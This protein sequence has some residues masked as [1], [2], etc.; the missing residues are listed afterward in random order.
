M[1]CHKVT[2]AFLELPVLLLSLI[3]RLE[4][5]FQSFDV[6]KVF[7]GVHL[8]FFESKVLHQFYFRKN[9]LFPH[10][11]RNSVHYLL[12]VSHI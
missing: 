8:Q 1:V 11:V 2:Q 3:D 6:F 10:L 4:F 12:D 7:C 9:Y 5:V